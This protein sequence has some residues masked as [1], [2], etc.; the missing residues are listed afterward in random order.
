MKVLLV[1]PSTTVYGDDPS[2]PPV[3]QPLGLAYLA[4][5]LEKEGHTVKVIDGRGGREDKTQTPTYTRFGIPDEEIFKQVKDFNPAV[6]GISNMFTA[7]SGDPHR[8]AK[9]IKKRHP[10]L[11]IIFGGS[12]PSEFPELVMKDENVDM[13]V[14]GEGEITFT[15]VLKKIQDKESFSNVL[16]L[17]YRERGNIIQNS[18]RERMADIDSLPLPARHLL[19]MEHYINESMRHDFIMRKPAGAMVTS[20]GCPQKCVFC[21]VRAV[22]G[23]D[24]TGRHPSKVVDEIE[25]LQEKYNLREV[26][27]LD[28][29]LG[30]DIP[31]LGAICDE[32]IRRKVDIRWT[33]PNGVAHWLLNESLLDKMKASGCY[34]LT[35]GIESGNKETRKFIKKKVPLEQATRMISHANKIG[36]WTI[37]TFILGFPY[38]KKEHMRDS[39]RYAVESGTDMAVFYLL[40][41]HPTSDVYSVFKEEGLL[42]LDPI[43]DPTTYKEAADFAEIGEVLSQRGAQTKYCSPEELQE[44]L[45]EAYKTFFKARLKKWAIN[46]LHFL[47]KVNSYEDL[48]YTLKVGNALA[49]PIRKFVT[50]KQAHIN[51]LWDKFNE[52]D[53]FS[54][55]RI[56]KSPEE[57]AENKSAAPLI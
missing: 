55:A 40:L 2:V 12:H 8:I 52:K 36:L 31:R 35:F 57:I 45:N 47:K 38:E 51:M 21:T 17:T 20:R 48:K 34:R 29:D 6:L 44:M 49:A 15:E 19:P 43:M 39:I 26:S 56:Y 11:P 23:R 28:D 32:I 3:V 41:P 14:K 30:R 9:G 25:F 27:F 4:A 10:R 54:K 13:V 50:A 5:Y 7:Y 46:P 1:F 24:W 33:T 53:A 18:P 42:D 16:G 22:W 37:C